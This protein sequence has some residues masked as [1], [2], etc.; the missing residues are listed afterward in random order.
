MS[1]AKV[2]F[3]LNGRELEILCSIED[4]MEQICQKYAFKIRRNMNSLIFFMEEAN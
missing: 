2:F 3:I 1:K 4:T